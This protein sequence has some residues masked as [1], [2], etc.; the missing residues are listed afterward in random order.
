M[1]ILTV[2]LQFLTENGRNF[3]KIIKQRPRE[4][5]ALVISDLSTGSWPLSPC[6]KIN[7]DFPPN[8]KVKNDQNLDLA[9][10]NPPTSRQLITFAWFISNFYRI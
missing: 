2:F 4:Q 10:Q 8:F 3:E 6:K 5:L 9:K 1:G 7:L